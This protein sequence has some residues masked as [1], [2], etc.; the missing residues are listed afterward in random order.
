[1][2]D[3]GVLNSLTIL[4]EPL[5]IKTAET[6]PVQFEVRIVWVVSLLSVGGISS[7]MSYDKD[8][9]PTYLP[10]GMNN[11]L[12]S[13]IGCA[14]LAVEFAKRLGSH[15]IMSVVGFPYLKH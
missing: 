12:Q 1:M 5:L 8:G 13:K 7:E 4:L 9:A 15:G 11:Y 2:A 10:G 6:S 14:W 3:D